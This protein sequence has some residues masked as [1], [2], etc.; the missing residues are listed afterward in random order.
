MSAVRRAA[1]VVA[2]RRDHGEWRCLMLRAYRNWDFPKGELQPG[3]DPLAAA[4][5]E[6]SE[7][8]TLDEVSMPWGAGYCETAPYGGKIARYYIAES[9]DGVVSLPVSPELGRPEHHEFRWVT[10]AEARVLAPARLQPILVWAARM[11]GE[12]SHPA[13]SPAA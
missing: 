9:R 12:G 4:H 10:L 5:R 13:E 7:E 3:E 11:L 1:G 2:F 8:T 6:L